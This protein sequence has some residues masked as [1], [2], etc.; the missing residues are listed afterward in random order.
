[1]RI[2]RPHLALRPTSSTPEAPAADESAVT[3]V[4]A[5]FGTPAPAHHMSST[6]LTTTLTLFIMGIVLLGA[7]INVALIWR[8]FGELNTSVQADLRWK[9]EAGAREIAASDDVAIALGELPATGSRLAAYMK[10][11]DVRAAVVLNPEG[12]TVI[13]RGRA[14]VPVKQLFSGAEGEVQ[15][16]GVAL[17]S[18][19]AARIEGQEVGRIALQISKQRLKASQTLRS[20]MMMLGAV[21]CLL[22]IAVSIVFVR[23]Y[24]RPLLRFADRTLEQL[25]E[26]N[27]TLEGKV[28]RRTSALSRAN[29]DLAASLDE[30][31]ATQAR[32]VDA[33]RRA[34]MADVATTVLH[35]VGNI[36]NSVNVSSEVLVETIQTSTTRNLDPL[37]ALLREHSGDLGA[38][39]GAD[40]R[41]KKLAPFVA[42]LADAAAQERK[43]LLTEAHAVRENVNHIKSIV[44]RQQQLA[45]G[46]IGVTE[47]VELGD[48]IDGVVG[49]VMPSFEKHGVSLERNCPPDLWLALDRHKVFEILINLLTNAQQAV[50]G[51]AGP[52]AVSVKARMAEPEE[53]AAAFIEI[54]VTDNGVGI[55]AGDETRLFQQGFTTKKT[56]HG[57]GL[58]GSACQA[59]EM[60]GALR[61]SSRGLGQGATFVLELPA[62]ASSRPVQSMQSPNGTDRA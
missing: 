33:S 53:G 24:L 46:R 59:I 38:F 28:L 23:F 9:A 32:L 21:G 5:G 54:E 8:A 34:G 11:A 39:V 42:S 43:R 6:R 51:N 13:E 41:G 10:T 35:N 47:R 61:A 2:S 17:W 40:P 58:H 14:D 26:L 36:L 16:S 60:G 18:W 45:D 37:A 29:K 48:L 30:L 1:V 62:A 25:R 22:A 12:R 52:K 4:E 31:H 3:S 27:A 56:G 55:A 50:A 49:M 7:G 19:S 44:S 57:I 20:R 15:E